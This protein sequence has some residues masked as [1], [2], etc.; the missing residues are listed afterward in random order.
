MPNC[1]SSSRPSSALAGGRDHRDVHALLERDGRAVDFGEDRLLGEPE[2]VVAVL[3]EPVRVQAAEVL[4]AG[5]RQRDHAVEELVHPRA[6]ERDLQAGLLPFADLEVRDALLGLAADG[7]LAG[8]DCRA[9]SRPARSWPCLRRRSTATCPRPSRSRSS[10]GAGRPAVL[11][12]ELLLQ[13]RDDLVVG[14]SPISRARRRGLL[15]SVVGCPAAPRGGLGSLRC[16]VLAAPW[17]CA[18][19]ALGRAACPVLSLFCSAHD[20]LSAIDC[21]SIAELPDR[22][23]RSRASSPC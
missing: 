10:P 20:F 11:V 13:G 23:R 22:S 15:R 17:A 3:V 14:T 21:R 5:D 2:V 19:L 7:L 8:D 4:H 18:A 6:A 1:L 12:P 9:P 16:F